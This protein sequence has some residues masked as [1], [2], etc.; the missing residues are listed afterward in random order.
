M[1]LYSYATRF[2]NTVTWNMYILLSTA[3]F[4]ERNTLFIFLW[5]RLKNA[6]IPIQYVGS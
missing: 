4:T 6:L 1:V 2:M 5:L 3:E